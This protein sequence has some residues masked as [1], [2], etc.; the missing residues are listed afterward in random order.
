[1]SLQHA[2]SKSGY[3]TLDDAEQVELRRVLAEDGDDAAARAFGVS[4]FTLAR[5]AAGCA[6]QYGSAHV[7]RAGLSRKA[8]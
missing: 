2:K 1:M 7:I 4:K 3:V 5:A 6:L 8:P